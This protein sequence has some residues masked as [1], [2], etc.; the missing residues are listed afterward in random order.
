MAGQDCRD[1]PPEGAESGGVE[2]LPS[3]QAFRA[4]KGA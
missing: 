1:R 2:L 4:L 3:L